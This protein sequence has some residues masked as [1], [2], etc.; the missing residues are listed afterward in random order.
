MEKIKVMVLELVLAIFLIIAIL[1]PP[2]KY[3]FTKE[4]YTRTSEYGSF[5]QEGQYYEFKQ[6][7]YV[8][9]NPQTTF[10]NEE[11]QEKRYFKRNLLYGELAVECLLGL[12]IYS[13]SLFI[14]NKI[15]NL[16]DDE[17]S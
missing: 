13:L 16:K 8:F 17:K 11:H 3:S 9:S 15:T 12:V 2:Y 10:W 4:G 7:E 1:F 5:H 14:K 6:Y